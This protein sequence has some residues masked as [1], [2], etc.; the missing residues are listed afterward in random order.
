MYKKNTHHYNTRLFLIMILAKTGIGSSQATYA[1]LSQYVLTA[2][3]NGKPLSVFS[4]NIQY[5][6][7]NIGPWY[8][9]GAIMWPESYHNTATVHLPTEYKIPVGPRPFSNQNIGLT[10]QTCNHS[11]ICTNQFFSTSSF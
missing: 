10:N 6:I 2:V 9:T 1:W 4:A 5:C 7:N 11:A 3:K 8:F